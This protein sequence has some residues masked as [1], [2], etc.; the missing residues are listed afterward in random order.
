MNFSDLTTLKIG[1]PIEKV[2]PIHTDDELVLNLKS[3]ISHTPALQVNHKSY[4]IIGGGSNL[5][6]SDQGFNGIVIKN[7]ITGIAKKDNQL[8][9]KSGTL[10]QNLVDFANNAGLAGLE[11]LAGIPGT[12]GGAIFGNAGAYGQTISDHLVSLKAVKCSSVTNP[13]H[14]ELSSSTIDQTTVKNFF[15]DDCRFGYRDSIFKRN[16]FIILEAVF[17][18]TPAEARILK[19]VSLETIKKRE[20]KYPPGIKC[21]G[22][23]FKNIPADTLS[24][25]I[26]NKLPKEFILYGKVSAGALLESVGARGARQGDILI[27]PYHANLFIN[28]GRGTAEDFYALAK[29]YSQKVFDKFGIR[30]EPEVQLINLPPLI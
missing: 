20:V 26:L 29:T 25:E 11:S 19:Q 15:K 22:S 17:D 12:L 13:L 8:T 14:P 1:G 23:F 2:I 16:Q 7:E 3:L 9:V 6:V 10:L 27:A 28:Q 18:L 5:L 24:A 4:F 21:P 30:L